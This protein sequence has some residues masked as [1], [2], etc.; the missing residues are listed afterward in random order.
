MII[1]KINI[2]YQLQIKTPILNKLTILMMQ[3]KVLI[4]I[5]FQWMII[6]I[7]GLLI[8]YITIKML[9]MDSKRYDKNLVII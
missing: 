4:K 9:Q 1:L 8:M 6:L 7:I 5:F 2:R 3:S